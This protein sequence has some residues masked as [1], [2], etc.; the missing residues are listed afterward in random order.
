MLSVISRI[1]MFYVTD[2]LEIKCDFFLSHRPS[3]QK[4]LTMALVAIYQQKES[5]RIKNPWSS[6]VLLLMLGLTPWGCTH[7]PKKGLE[8][9][10]LEF[11]GLKYKKE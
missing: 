1:M 8:E 10:R 7:R 6:H 9:M 3:C 2:V 5:A 11:H 4:R